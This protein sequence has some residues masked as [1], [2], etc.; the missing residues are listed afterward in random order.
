MELRQLRTFIAAAESQNF[1]R[2]AEAVS[3]TQAAVSQ[4]IAALE[5]SLEVSLFQRDGRS[6]VLTGE[7]RQLYQYARRILDLID[8]ARQAV[9][10]KQAALDGPLRIA[11]SSVP[12]ELLLPE[13]LAE[14]RTRYPQIRET[15]IVSDSADANRTVARGEADVG[16]VGELS[17]TAKLTAR[18]IGDDEL[19]L[20]IAPNHPFAERKRVTLKRLCREPLIFREPGSG[21]RRC[22][23][24]ALEAEGITLD[25]LN[26]VMVT[27]SNDSIRSAVERNVGIAFLS[28]PTI[29]SELAD[30]RLATLTVQTLRPRRQLYLITNPERIPPRPARAFLEFIEERFS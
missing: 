21:S 5:T 22:V 25:E 14:F 19:V 8:E 30:G 17:Q 2:A 23:E 7:G 12:A 15:V 4:Q 24:R 16:F 26:I 13:L 9:G 10:G 27:N 18:P 11:A 20:V 28:K 29:A 6:V 3:L 1:T